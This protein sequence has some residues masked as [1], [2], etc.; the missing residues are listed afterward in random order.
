M[1]KNKMKCDLHTHTVH[2]D[3]TYTPHELAVA[4]KNAGLS[5]IAL[6]DH[7]SVSGLEEFSR[8]AEAVGIE[9]ATGVEFST[10]YKGLELHVIGMFIHS[11]SYDAI[12][13]F[14]GDLKEMKNRAN[15]ELVARLLPLGYEIDYDMLLAKTPEGYVNRAHI[16]AD[17]LKKGYVK[18]FNEAFEGVLSEGAGYYIP[19]RRRGFFETL[20]FI[21]SIGAV[22]VLAHPLLQL[23]EDEL[24]ALLPEAIMHGLSAIETQYVKYTQEQRDFSSAL[25]QKFGI[26]ESGGSDFH[27]EN[28]PYQKLGVGMGELFVPYE[29]YEKLKEKALNP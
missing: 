20:D 11:Y 24:S 19:P 3:G 21:S 27:G 25:A 12:T 4:A 5:A 28:K 18:S 22:S 17:M 9:Y 29:F 23:S 13:E 7:N 8:S 6:T 14:I 15:R 26:L 16:A 1:R 10:E 2:S